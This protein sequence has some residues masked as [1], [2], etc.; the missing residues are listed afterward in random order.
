MC[1]AAS[2]LTNVL[3]SDNFVNISD[4]FD[5]GS[6]CVLPTRGA[7]VSLANTIGGMKTMFCR[8]AVLMAEKSP[9]LTQ[10]QLA[11]E[12]GVGTATIGRL[13]NNNFERVDKQTIEKLCNYFDCRLDDLFVLVEA[14]K[15]AKR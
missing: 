11:R 10:R 5:F 3:A 7:I 4:N 12:L 9:Q 14:T 15:Q 6:G 2:V 1:F 13:H 8:L